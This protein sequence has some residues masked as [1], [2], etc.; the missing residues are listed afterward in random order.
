MSLTSSQSSSKSSLGITTAA[1][2]KYL[3][4]GDGQT[5][6]ENRESDRFNGYMLI[7]AH[8]LSLG[9]TLVTNNVREFG[10]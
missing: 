1:R 10:R 6:S 3:K 5:L 7:G 8:A 4:S 2:E 9:L